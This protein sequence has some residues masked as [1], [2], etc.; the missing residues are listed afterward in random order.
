[1]LLEL[2][3]LN[4]NVPEESLDKCLNWGFQVVNEEYQ[5]LKDV[6]ASLK[7]FLFTV[8][9]AATHSLTNSLTHSSVGR[10]TTPL[11]HIC[12]GKGDHHKLIDCLYQIRKQSII[13]KGK[14]LRDIKI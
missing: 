13:R 7:I 6:K 11:H 9:N 2:L 3:L 1:M 14:I 10:T 8:Q 5:Q 4:L 12:E